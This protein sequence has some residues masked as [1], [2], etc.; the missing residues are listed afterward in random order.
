M[1]TLSSKAKIGIFGALLVVLLGLAILFGSGILRFGLEGPFVYVIYIIAGLLVAFACFGLLDSSGELTGQPLD[2]NLK[3]GGAIVG[4]VVVAAGGALYEIYGR[5]PSTFST[6][7]IFSDA[8]GQQVKPKGTLTLFI[9]A[10]NPQI[11][12]DGN[13]SALFQNLPGAWRN[14]SVRAALDSAEFRPSDSQGSSLQLKPEETISLEVVRK[15]L[16]APSDE[17][18]IDFSWKFGES[19]QLAASSDRD[20]TIRL[21]AI[22]QSELPV[23]LRPK[24]TL[25]FFRQGRPMPI[26]TI[27][28]DIGTEISDDTVILQPHQ[29]TTLIFSGLLSRDLTTLAYRRDLVGRFKANYLDSAGKADREFVSPDFPIDRSTVTFDR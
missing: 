3:L 10:A 25:I 19:V 23:P 5:P 26:R 11:T 8:T 15:P 21:I 14:K 22:A 12:I 9:G 18:K 7:V 13:G 6:R 1:S 20:L 17:A 2:T 16:F 29:P 28:V 27:Q 4:L 24:G